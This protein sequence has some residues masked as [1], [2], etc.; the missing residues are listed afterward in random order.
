MVSELEMITYLNLCGGWIVI[1]K[2]EYCGLKPTIEQICSS[3]FRTAS[4]KILRGRPINDCY[5]IQHAYKIQCLMN[6]SE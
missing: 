5:T 1:K 4:Y 3:S 6:G 2:F